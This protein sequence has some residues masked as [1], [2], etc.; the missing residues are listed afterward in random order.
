M[1]DTS[2]LREHD[3]L[4]TASFF[5]RLS[6]VEGFEVHDESDASFGWADVTKLLLSN[7]QSRLSTY[8][9]YRL[10]ANLGALRVMS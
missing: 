6:D 5:D 10:V 1:V 7:R 2:A 3:V 8:Q 9:G 4:R